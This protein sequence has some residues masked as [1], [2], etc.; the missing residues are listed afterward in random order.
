MRMILLLALLLAPCAGAAT[1]V[2][3]GEQELTIPEYEGF[4]QV[5]P[6]MPAWSRFAEAVAAE[7]RLALFVADEDVLV[8]PGT[9]QVTMNIAA[10]PQFAEH[11][12]SRELFAGYRGL[13]RDRVSQERAE[14][15][16]DP[17]RTVVPGFAFDDERAIGHTQCELYSPSEDREPVTMCRTS[18]SVWLG[19]RLLHINVVA[20]GPWAQMNSAI[21]AG[22]YLGTLIAANPG[23]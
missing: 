11:P 1:T 14:V 2:S 8:A 16:D 9:G 19:Q 17:S 12:M 15:E 23:L 6:H 20:H 22:G 7:G 18:V 3:L 4:T 5:G 21:V 13:Y 10:N